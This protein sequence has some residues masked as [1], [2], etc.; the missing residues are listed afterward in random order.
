MQPVIITLDFQT[1]AATLFDAWTNPAVMRHW[2]FK[3]DHS[4]IES[5]DLDLTV[6][7][8]F[9]ILERD[10]SGTIDHFGNYLLIDQPTSLS[11]T[12]EVP[13]HFV[14]MTQVLLNFK[15]RG[16]SCEMSFEQTG[17]D[18]KVVESSWMRMFA[19]LTRVLN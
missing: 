14:G 11:F 6:G 3:G 10:D 13:K 1:P 7:G 15:P 9:S 8:F 18:P 4:E 2:L 16:N 17:V 12:L 19:K 5:I